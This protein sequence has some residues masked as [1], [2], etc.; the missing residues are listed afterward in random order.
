[1]IDITINDILNDSTPDTEGHKIYIVYDGDYIFYI[2]RSKCPVSRILSHIGLPSGW[3]ALS[4]DLGKLIRAN[5]PHSRQWQVKLL[6]LQDFGIEEQGVLKDKLPIE[7][8]EERLI[9]HFS[10]YC[11]TQFRRRGVPRILPERYKD[12][13]PKI[14]NEGVILK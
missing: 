8:L 9:Y 11:N 12:P 4:S 2:G 14:A 5:L 13:A 1:M 7:D 3:P 6:S 10:P